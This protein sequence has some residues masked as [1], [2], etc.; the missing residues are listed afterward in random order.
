[1]K[2]DEQ[3][4]TKRNILSQIA[5]CSSRWAGYLQWQIELKSLFSPLGSKDW[6]EIFPCMRKTVGDRCKKSLET[7]EVPRWLS[8][9]HNQQSLEL[10]GVGDALEWTYAV[11]VYLRAEEEGGK[12]SFIAAKT[13][14]APVKQVSLPRLELCAATLPVQLIAYLREVLKLQVTAVHIWLNSTAFELDTSS[15][16]RSRASSRLTL[17]DGR[18]HGG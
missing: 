7:T 5:S 8:G 13:K 11:V 2:N 1:M 18:V 10:H 3:P 15:S 16:T 17:C 12:L 9:S 4:I 14:V 6:T